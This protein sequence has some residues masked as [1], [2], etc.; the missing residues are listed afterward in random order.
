LI[1]VFAAHS[2]VGVGCSL[3]DKIGELPQLEQSMGRFKTLVAQS[4]SQY[5]VSLLSICFVSDIQDN[6]SGTLL[7]ASEDER[8]S[9]LTKVSQ[10]PLGDFEATF[11]SII[12]KSQNLTTIATPVAVHEWS[13]DQK[14]K[15]WEDRKSLD[16]SMGQLLK[17]I[18]G[19]LGASGRNAIVKQ[20]IHLEEEDD[21]EEKD[22]PT[23][24]LALSKELQQFPWENL[25]SFAGHAVCRIPNIQMAL[26]CMARQKT[27]DCEDVSSANGSFVIDP[28]GD[29][30]GTREMLERSVKRFEST[31]AAWSGASGRAPSSDE[32]S[33]LVHG[34]GVFLFSG[35]GNGEQFMPREKIGR[36]KPREVIMLMGCSSA[37]LFDEG[38]FEPE[39]IPISYLLSGCR[40]VIGYL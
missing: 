6:S 23:I 16:Q 5:S 17:D 18:D 14:K 32:F 37:K 39:G 8:G 12:E 21:E 15:W 27:P 33:Q 26:E 40:N 34:D 4:L 19:A 7:I 28:L 22:S 25:P 31:E 9:N 1:R 35:H 36:M 2:S 10:F 11:L 20:V 38:E 3:E 30:K 13:K 29:L 24:L